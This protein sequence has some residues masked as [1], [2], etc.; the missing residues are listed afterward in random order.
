MDPQAC[1]QRILEACTEKDWKEAFYAMNDLYEWLLMGGFPPKIPP[2]TYISVG[3][4]GAT[5]YSI[6]SKPQG[7]GA[8]FEVYRFSYSSRR[9]ELYKTFHLDGEEQQ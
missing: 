6:L 5:V 9:Y 1:F 4:G 3:I 7:K 2:R 8:V